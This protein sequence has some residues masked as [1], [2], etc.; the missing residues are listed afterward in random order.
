MLVQDMHYAEFA[1]D[2]V[3]LTSQSTR[4]QQT[5]TDVE[6]E[7]SVACRDQGIRCK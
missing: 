7:C 4:L 2:E 1:E 3:S 6:A 5:N